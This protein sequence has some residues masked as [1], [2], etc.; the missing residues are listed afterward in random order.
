[1]CSMV[2]SAYA[3]YVQSMVE[4]GERKI[5]EINWLF[6]SVDRSLKYAQMNF[7]DGKI[8]KAY[9][10]LRHAKNLTGFLRR[11]LGNIPDTKLRKHLEEFF[12]YV[13]QALETSLRAEINGELKEMQELLSQLH[14]GW[15]H[16]VSPLRGVVFPEPT[17]NKAA[18]EL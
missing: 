12:S 2:D 10:S 5:T 16:L 1:M 3:K 17:E 4:H 8:S 15:L 14:L 18:Q 11:S 13:D 6:E 7:L 9:S